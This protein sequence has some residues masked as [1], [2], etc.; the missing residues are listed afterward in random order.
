M[1]DKFLFNFFFKNKLIKVNK[2]LLIEILC[3]NWDIFVIKE[4]FDIGFINV[5]EY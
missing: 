5:V 3:W 1:D 2:I 4:N